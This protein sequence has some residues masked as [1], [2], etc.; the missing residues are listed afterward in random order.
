MTVYGLTGGARKHAVP[1]F[2]YLMESSHLDRARKS[3]ELRTI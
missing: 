1:F 2:M 3:R